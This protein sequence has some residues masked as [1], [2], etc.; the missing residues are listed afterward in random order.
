MTMSTTTTEAAV[1]TGT[2]TEYIQIHAIVHFPASNPNRDRDGEPKKIIMGNTERGRISAQCL[3]RTLRTSDIFLDAFGPD[4]GAGHMGERTKEMGDVVYKNLLKGG[5]APADAEQWALVIAA[6]F[7]VTKPEKKNTMDHLKNETLFFSSPKE[8]ASLDAYVGKIIAEKTPPPNVKGKEEMEKAA[9]KIRPLILTHEHSAVDI[10]MFGRFFA[11]DKEYSS[12][13]CVQ[14]A[15]AFTVHPYQVEDDFFTAVDDRKERGDSDEDRGGGHL[16]NSPIG[17]GVFY[18][19][20]TINRTAL[21]KQ[22]RDEDLVRRSCRC[23]VEAM[24]T[25][26]PK[27]KGN[28]SAQQSR[29]LYGRVE[30]GWKTPRNLSLAFLDAIEKKNIWQ[31]AIERLRETAANID[32]V[33]GA[34][35]SEMKEFNVMTGEGTLGE[36][37]DLAGR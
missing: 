36:L 3:K 26:F 31:T 23:M 20:A 30:R 29:A 10:A 15:H 14:V 1:R 4:L 24:M 6:V 5:L 33:Y 34:C 12:D 21:L 17:A 2:K 13:A 16:G 25:V 19:H 18:Y 8:R 22:L 9:M 27:A 28:S 7:G 37:G 32:K 11:Q 35:Y